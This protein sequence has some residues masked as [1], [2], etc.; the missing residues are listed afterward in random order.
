MTVKFAQHLSNPI[1]F[2]TM[3]NNMRQVIIIGCLGQ[4]KSTLL[5]K[6]AFVNQLLK[7]H[8]NGVGN[9]NIKYEDSKFIASNVELV[10]V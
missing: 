5:N 7:N 6:I 8:R 3:E 1:C 10:T 9:A 4:G 2:T